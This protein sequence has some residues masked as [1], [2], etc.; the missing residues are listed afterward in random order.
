MFVSG[1][2]VNYLM[3]SGLGYL[4]GDIDLMLNDLMS[5]KEWH[6]CTVLTIRS[7]STL[8]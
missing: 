8:R 7:Q 2:A 4:R 6:S 3:L 1:I 5:S